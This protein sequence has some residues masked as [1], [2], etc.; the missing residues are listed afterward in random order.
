[1]AVYIHDT[2]K[3][4]IIDDVFLHKKCKFMLNRAL[5]KKIPAPTFMANEY[6][7]YLTTRTASLT[8]L[9]RLDT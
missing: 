2:K 8:N 5:V 9:L 1:M 6:F 3:N 7:R 4:I